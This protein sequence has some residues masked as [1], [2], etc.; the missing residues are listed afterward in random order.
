MNNNNILYKKKDNVFVFNYKYDKP[1]T[2][3]ISNLLNNCEIII[4]SDFGTWES[5]MKNYYKIYENKFNGRFKGSIFNLPL[6]NLPNTIKKIFLGYSFNTQLDNLP[7]SLEL[8]K[9]GCCYNQSLDYLP[10]SLNILILNTK[11]IPIYNLPI[12]LKVLVSKTDI[13]INNLPNKDLIILS[14]SMCISDDLVYDEYL[15]YVFH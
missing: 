13:Q 14:T 2:N 1:I 6:N 7:S 15:K 3:K 8:L 5:T 10:E 4:F 9:L 12:S 11:N